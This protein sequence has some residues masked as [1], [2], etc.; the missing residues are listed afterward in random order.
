MLIITYNNL[1]GAVPIMIGLIVIALL[2]FLE[3]GL[4][5]FVKDE[6]PSE[7]LNDPYTK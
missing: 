3:I 6:Q 2:A 5:S 7:S 4:A 1:K